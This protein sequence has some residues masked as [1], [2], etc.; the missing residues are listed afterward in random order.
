MITVSASGYVHMSKFFSPEQITLASFIKR[1]VFS[2]WSLSIIAPLGISTKSIL[3]SSLIR[4]PSSIFIPR[5]SGKVL[6]LL[7]AD[8]IRSNPETRIYGTMLHGSC[9]PADRTRPCWSLYP[10]LFVAS[11]RNGILEGGLKLRP[12]SKFTHWGC[13]TQN[14]SSREN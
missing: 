10:L 14:T 2:M 7:L 8:L 12:I 3:C 13:V 4:V 9:G 11:N 1:L 5:G 6:V